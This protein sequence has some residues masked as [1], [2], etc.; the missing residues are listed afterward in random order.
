VQ[1]QR[2]SGFL[3]KAGHHI[4]HARR[5]PGLQC[6]FAEAQRRERRLFGRLQH[7]RIARQQRGTHLPGGDDQ[8]IVP[9]H[10]RA[11]D[12]ERLAPHQRQVLRPGRGDFVVELVGEFTVIGDAG[13]GGWDVGTERV[14]DRLPHIERLEQGEVVEVIAHQLRKPQQ[15]PLALLR[16]HVAP[17]ALVE[18]P[19]RRGHGVVDI[20]CLAAGDGGQFAAV[21]GTQ[22]VEA[23]AAACG[24]AL[25]VNDGAAVGLQ[26][27][28]A[29][30]PVDACLGW[31]LAGHGR[32]PSQPQRGRKP[33]IGM[34]LSKKVMEFPPGVVVSMRAV[35]RYY[36]AT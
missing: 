8:R 14:A 9:G 10:D 25:P 3:A 35:A 27:P 5:N 17:A 32:R 36:D 26:F 19:A 16:F 22:G 24:A 1:R 23:A 31:L 28:R 29:A 11:H 2:L 21:D 18:R 33:I 6:Q 13:R 7:H 12:T 30:R 15:H 20:L 4:Q 34:S